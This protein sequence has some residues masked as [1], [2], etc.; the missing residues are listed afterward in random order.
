VKNGYLFGAY[1][2]EGLLGR[3]G[4]GEVY[5]AYDETHKRVVALKVLPLQLATDETYRA[6]FRRESELAARL[7]EAHVIPIHQYGEIDGQLFLDMRLVDGSDLGTVL[8]QGGALGP[9]RAVNIVSQVAQA[10]DAAHAD[11]LIHRDVK[12]S[13]VLISGGDDPDSD[14]FVYLVDF[15]IARASEDDGQRLTMTGGAMGSFDYMAPERF[16]QGT[17]DRRADVYSLACTLFECLTGRRPFP[18]EGPALMYQHLNTPPT[19]SLRH[20]REPAGRVGSRH[21]PRNGQASRG[22]LPPGRETRRSGP[23]RPRGVNR[24][25]GSG[26]PSVVCH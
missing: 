25:A 1:R 4:M 11:G 12:P 15:G 26:P 18:V 2:I 23:P 10:L 5:R 16:L 22:P 3:G 9:K 6:R 20:S 19:T 24:R 21:R 7:R 8:A 13:N 14:D 17:V